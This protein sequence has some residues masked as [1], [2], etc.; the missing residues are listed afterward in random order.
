MVLTMRRD[1]LLPVT[2]GERISTAFHYS[3]TAWAALVIWLWV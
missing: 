3:T 2:H 1:L